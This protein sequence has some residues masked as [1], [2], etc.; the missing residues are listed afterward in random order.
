MEVKV[1]LD[2]HTMRDY[3]SYISYKTTLHKQSMEPI[4]LFN[5]GQIT[6]NNRKTIFKSR[7]S[8]LPEISY[9]LS[10]ITEITEI[11]LEIIEIVC[12]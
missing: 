2:P 9:A 6:S 3:K 12:Q 11:T 4:V 10:E 1:F 7:G 8:P 5:S